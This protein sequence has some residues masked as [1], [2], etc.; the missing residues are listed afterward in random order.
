MSRIFQRKIKSLLSF[1]CFSSLLSPGI[2]AEASYSSSTLRLNDIKLFSE[3][4]LIQENFISRREDDNASRGECEVAEG[5][6]FRLTALVPL[7]SSRIRPLTTSSHP[8]FWVYSPYT[9]SENTIINFALYNRSDTSQANPIYETNLSN[10]EAGIIRI[11]MPSS[12]PHL[13]E[14]N[15]YEWFFEVYCDDTSPNYVIGNII[16]VDNLTN[17]ELAWYDRVT[18][19]ANRLNNGQMH[20]WL[21]LLESVG[22][23]F[24]ADQ[25]ISN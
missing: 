1:L 6:G 8:T 22:L 25:E 7:A 11:P 4:F 23:E 14:G 16:F 13:I 24:L 17:I 2:V 15:E 21:S 20:E 10:I 9:T 12:A 3:D 19:L 18:E 5:N